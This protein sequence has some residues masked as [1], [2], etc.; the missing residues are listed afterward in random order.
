MDEKDDIVR[1]FSR[2]CSM[3]DGQCCKRGVFTVFEWEAKKL[4]SAY[5]EFQE[6]NVFDERGGCKDIAM[7]GLCMFSKKNGCELPIE[8]RPTDCLTFP[9]YPEL[10]ADEDGLD[11]E[12]ILI[13]NECPFSNEISKNKK[14]I[15]YMNN[16]WKD[17]IKKTTQK[18]ITDWIGENGCWGEWYKNAIAVKQLK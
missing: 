14:L 11:I 17:I 13:Q 1:E 2:Y 7:H 15:K 4:S 10:K 5:P 8:L 6:A 16:F 9:F 18:E 3:C 12:T